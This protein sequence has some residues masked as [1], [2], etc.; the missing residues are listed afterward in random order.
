MA[1][2]VLLCLCGCLP[3]QETKP[4]EPA[5]VRVTHQVV[6]EKPARLGV[7]IG[8][9]AYWSDLQQVANP[10]AH[11]GFSMGRQTLLIQAAPGASGTV[12]RDN[13]FDP[14]DPDRRY[15]ES[16][17]GGEYCIGTG[18]RAGER[19]AIASH[20]L[21]TGTFTLEKDGAPLAENE[22]LWL[23]GP[24]VRRAQPDPQDKNVERTIGIGDF[25]PIE[26]DGVKVSLV[27][28]GRAEGDQAVRVSFSGAG[29]GGVKHYIRG[30]SNNTY[31]VHV[32][33]RA[34]GEGMVLQAGMRNFGI[35]YPDEGNAIELRPQGDTT[36]GADW[37]EYRFIGSTPDDKRMAEESSVFEIVV[38][39]EAA[40]AGSHAEID[41][42][43]LEDEGMKSAHGFNRQMAQAMAEAQ[44]GVLRFY[45]VSSLGSLVEDFTAA[46]TTD[47]SWTFASLA[48]SARLNPTDAVVD[49]WMRLCE[50]VGAQP[51]I[52]VGSANSPAD[53]ERLISYLCAPADFDRDSQRRADHGFESP[54]AS[55]F[56][57]IYLEIGNEWWNPVFR[58]YHVMPPEKYAQL[59]KLITDT[60]KAH[61][62]F[63]AARVKLVAGG[64]AAN[65]HHWNGAV[66][67][68]SGADMVSIAPYLLQELND[69]ASKPK[70]LN[71]LFGDVEGYAA[72]GGKS[73]LED[74]AAHGNRMRVGVYELNTHLTGGGAPANI[75]SEIT[76][77]AAAG[78]AV[79]D[80]AMAVMRDMNAS[81]INYFTI[82]QRSYNDR[83]GL[84]GAMLREPDGRLRARPVWQGLRL[85]N[86]HLIAGDMVEAAVDNSPTWDQPENGSVPEMDNVPYLHAYAFDDEDKLRVLVVNRHPEKELAFTFSLPVA[87]QPPV[88]VVRLAAKSPFDD[89]EEKETVALASEHLEQYTAGHKFT[90]PP[91]SATV[92]VFTE[93][94]H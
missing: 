29:A 32:R 72:T 92:Y 43:W 44:C 56:D 25:R 22:V 71:A 4:G 37:K 31:T 85:A 61:P 14:S 54:W 23:R 9:S 59:C 41:A 3:A 70:R 58:P 18:P 63:D 55:R 21:A 90:L 66:A 20:D 89:N 13:Y 30:I 35:A 91:A 34:N 11:G 39:A 67:E 51:W 19:G 5:L 81:P 52:T 45:G 12:V 69:Y 33:A 8:A 42:V 49:D 88:E 83:L 62:H 27:D 15:V 28:S 76:A 16:F 2:G 48:S 60:V 47:A 64:W 68:Q 87:V 53:W 86:Q 80:Q 26:D 65:G 73:T 1:A 57:T 6:V 79:L 46:S 17:A 82:L 38:N 75:A 94:P 77:S 7:N 93:S 40:A 36:L 24:L 84:W 78:V 50:E 10:F 74:L